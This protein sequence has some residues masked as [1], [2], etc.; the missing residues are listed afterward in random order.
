M[1]ELLLR[2]RLLTFHD[3]PL[4]GDASPDAFTYI[5]DG[6]LLIRDGKIWAI[7][8]YASRADIKIDER[9]TENDGPA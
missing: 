4:A 6:G 7:D 5:E 2:G 9:Y 8:D 3:E 1:T